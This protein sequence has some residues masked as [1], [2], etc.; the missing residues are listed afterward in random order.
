MK[1]DNAMKI[2]SATDED[3]EAI[4]VLWKSCF[5][6]EDTYIEFYFNKRFSPKYTALLEIDEEIVGMIHLLPCRIAPDRKALYWY[7]AGIRRD[8]RGNGLFRYLASHV[9]AAAG[10]R[11]FVNVC[12]PAPGLEKMY[13]ALGFSHAYT[14][15][16]QRYCKNKEENITLG[17]ALILPAKVRDFENLPIEIGDTIWDHSAIQYAFEENLLCD[18]H[19]IKIQYRNHTYFCFAIKKE[20]H[21]LLDNHNISP[22]IMI[23]IKGA[24]M[25]YLSCE[26][27]L[28]RQEGKEK[29]VGLCDTD[30]LTSKSKI[31]LTLS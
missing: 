7:A 2:R 17:T 25:N 13:Q 1:E 16:D 29:I 15:M 30:L 23:E 14:A 10:N 21:F 22:E 6:D 11:G 18:G 31:T 19:Q 27:I 9:L 3:R 20:D 4:K 24:I 28:L 5:D 26:S 12:M 8:M